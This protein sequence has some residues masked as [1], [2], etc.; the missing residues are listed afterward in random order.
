MIF[1]T[2]GSLKLS[3]H[4][5]C[6]PLSSFH[7][8]TGHFLQ[9]V[10]V[11]NSPICR[12]VNSLFVMCAVL[13]SFAK[14]SMFM[15]GE[16]NTSGLLHVSQFFSGQLTFVFTFVQILA[17]SITVHHFSPP[18]LSAWLRLQALRKIRFY[19]NRNH[20]K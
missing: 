17:S 9:R 7:F 11:Q 3:M 20:L 8:A 1:D 6:R 15:H 2:S 14:S 13:I 18:F 10:F 4:P 12:I 5:L 19:Q 16:R